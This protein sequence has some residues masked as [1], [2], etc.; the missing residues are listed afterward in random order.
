MIRTFMILLGVFFACIG[1]LAPYLSIDIPWGSEVWL[2]QAVSELNGHFRLAPTLN[3]F[4][5]TGPNPLVSVVLSLLPLPE[6]MTLRLVS[7]M[8][9]CLV[10]LGVFMFCSSIWDD[11]SGI[12][13]SLFT[14]TSWGFI[15]GFGN[16]NP[17]AIPAGLTILAFLLFS[18]IYLKEQNP[19]WYL[20]SY[21]LVAIAAA[22][23]GYLPL[24]F[25]VFSIVFLVLL[26]MAPRRFL[27]IKLPYLI[28]LLAVV[29]FTLYTAAWILEGSAYAKTLF[30][31]DDRTSLTARIWL[32][33]KFNLP[34]LL[35]VIPAWIY[36]EGSHE[37]GAW[38]TLLAPKTAYGVSLAAV[39]FTSSIQEGYAV[40]GIPFAGIIIGY[41]TAKG[42]L[43]R[44]SL[45]ILRTLSVA[46]TAAVLILSALVLISAGSIIDAVRALSFDISQ[47]VI[48][49]CFCIA[50]ALLL[51][52]AKKQHHG[53][54]IALS[55]VSVFSLSW[56]SALV[57]V[58]VKAQTPLSY[59]SQVSTFSPLLVYK[60]DLVMR[61][62]AGYVGASPIV[63]GEKMVPVGDSAY[64]AV[65]TDDIKDSLKDLSTRMKANLVSSSRQWTT[66][67]LIRVAPLT[68]KE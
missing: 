13:A 45:M 38:R 57:L 14:M 22:T 9:G 56:Y 63:V 65:R 3:G 18:Q 4:P 8:M 54:I 21:V 24:A 19:W 11:R 5:F 16:I 33:I 17:T 50:S 39:L 60:D 64:L 1:I 46:G 31:F 6:L 26:D 15:A 32:W 36:G 68:P 51:F 42:Y 66:Y 10:A 53:A 47:G 59:M 48:V 28:V 62:Y 27:S 55:I 40:L 12:Y 61:G 23:G 34:W 52:A 43:I 2:I 41:W 25:Y 35:L 30:S 67:A 20:L 58:P 7:I 37:A 29:L 49:L 44:Q